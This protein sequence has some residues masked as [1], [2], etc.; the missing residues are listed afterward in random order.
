MMCYYIN[1]HFQAQ[2]VNYRVQKWPPPV[3]ILSQ[4]NPVLPTILLLETPF[5]YY[6]PTYA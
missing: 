3:P 4:I 6:P 1:V 2:R 5:Q